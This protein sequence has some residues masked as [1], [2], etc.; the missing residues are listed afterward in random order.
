MGI[1]SKVVMLPAAV[2]AELDRL[3]V[4]RAFSGYQAL[5][6]RLQANGY[7][8]SDDSLQ[9]Y[10][11][12]LRHQLDALNLARYQAWVLAAAG[13]N[14]GDPADATTAITAR[15]I[16]QQVLSILP[17]AAEPLASSGRTNTGSQ[18]TGNGHGNPAHFRQMGE[19]CA[20]KSAGILDG[21]IKTMNL[22]ALVLLSRMRVHLNRI[23]SAQRNREQLSAQASEAGKQLTSEPESQKLFEQVNLAIRTAL[24]AGHRCAIAS[25]G[26]AQPVATVIEQMNGDGVAAPAESLE[27]PVV[28][29]HSPAETQH[30]PRE[31]RQSPPGTTQP[32]LTA[33]HRTSAHRDDAAPAEPRL[34]PA[35]ARQSPV[36]ARLSPAGTTQPQLTAP[37]RSSAHQI[38][39][40]Q[41]T[42]YG[43]R[44]RLA[45]SSIREACDF[46]LTSRRPS[47]GALANTS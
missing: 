30:S 23:I 7:R 3:I 15:Q 9:R 18:A 10:G 42:V 34:S 44:L 38:V 8:I 19:D 26:A 11:V 17:Q 32:Q 40:S 21:E 39:R 36:E 16:R 46:F 22:H 35:Q 13:K 29:Q 20:V 4:D 33:P 41:S 14:T 47:T 2:R 1:R 28:A 6:E 45:F 12:R 25:A 31:T 27:S 5:A 24:L 37:H 43:H